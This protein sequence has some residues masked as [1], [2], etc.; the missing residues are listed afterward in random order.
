MREETLEAEEKNHCGCQCHNVGK[1]EE[2]E[3]NI[4]SNSKQ[5]DHK[6]IVIS[7]GGYW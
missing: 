4:I 2:K 1:Q 5:S 3:K 7:R 6:G